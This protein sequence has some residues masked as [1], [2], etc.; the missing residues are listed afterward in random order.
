MQI[1]LELASARNQNKEFMGIFLDNQRF[2]SFMPFSPSNPF[3][4]LSDSSSERKTSTN[5]VSC[6][7]IIELRH[8]E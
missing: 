1:A 8:R 3:I 4:G 2:S 6:I 5:R 7:M